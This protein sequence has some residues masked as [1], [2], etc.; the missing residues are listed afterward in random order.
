MKKQIKIILLCLM[1]A[2]ILFFSAGLFVRLHHGVR[3]KPS[4]DYVDRE[5]IVLYR[6]DDA[7]WAKETL[8]ES[9][10]SMKSSGCLVSCIAAAVT[11]NGNSI[12]PGEI[13]ELFSA[14]H[15]YDTEG[16][17]QWE[18]ID[19]MNGYH[20]EVFDEVSSDV[21]EKC[22]DAGKYP[23][24]RVRMNGLGSFHYVLIVGTED[25]DYVCMDPLNDG[26]TRLSDYG[27]RVYAVRIVWYEKPIEEGMELYDE[28]LKSEYADLDYIYTYTDFDG[29]GK[30][31][32]CL[33]RND[34]ETQSGYVVKYQEKGLQFCYQ[35]KWTEHDLEKLDWLQTAELTDKTEHREEM[36][37]SGIYVYA[38]QE[39]YDGQTFWYR[40]VEEFLSGAGV[41][42]EAPF[43]EYYDPDGKPRLSLYYDEQTEKGCGIR[44]YERDPS[45]FSTSGMYGFTFSGTERMRWDENVNDYRKVE[46]VDGD[47]GSAGVDAYQ[48]NY[49]YDS[50]GRLT[51]FDSTGI[52]SFWSED[53]TE[54]QYILYIDYEYGADGQLKSRF[55]WHNSRCFGTWYTTWNSYFDTQG[56]VEYEDI[57]VTHGSIDHYFIY[58]ND[59]SKPD[60]MLILDNN[61]GSWIPEFRM[62]GKEETK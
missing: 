6:Q 51:H 47:N 19:K 7:E 39:P 42:G 37:H 34:T 35:K 17:V 5:N 62:F 57:Y 25:G 4:V 36:T 32:L 38:A 41:G 50:E 31:E 52:L 24:V 29:D 53:E 56:R 22:L 16:N 9:S 18:M 11:M 58:L 1:I 8:G 14:N 26:L 61:C 59:S 48:E 2:I 28:L 43:Y 54:P 20:T 27:N 13:N 55:Y 33:K 30:T 10:Y 60:Y 15:V 23:V 46:S 49:E 44:Y 45:T 12:N 21:V 40:N 3:L